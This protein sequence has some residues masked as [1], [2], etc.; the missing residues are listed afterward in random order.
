M[1]HKI[2]HVLKDHYLKGVIKFNAVVIEF[3]N[4]T[5]SY[6]NDIVHHRAQFINN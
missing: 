3:K 5:A 6:T 4:S 1:M 2:I